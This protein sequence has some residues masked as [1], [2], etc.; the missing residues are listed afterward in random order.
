MCQLLLGHADQAIEL[1]TKAR[2]ANP[3]VWIN[4]FVLAGALGVRGDLNE[5]KASLAESLKLKPEINSLTAFRTHRPSDSNP[6]F[7]ALAEKTLY[8]GLRNAGFPEE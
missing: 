8:A 2:A 6:Q 7:T 5:A 3:R 4:H 1:L